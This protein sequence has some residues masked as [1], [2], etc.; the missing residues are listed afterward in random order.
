[1]T[2]TSPTPTPIE[3]L[4]TIH[5]MASFVLNGNDGGVSYEDAVNYGCNGQDFDPFAKNSKPVD[6]TDRAF[7]NWKNCIQCVLGMGTENIPTYSYSADQ[8]SCGEFVCFQQE[9]RITQ[10]Y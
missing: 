7:L 6:H 8:D 2:S 9:I 5:E 10:F 4:T 1:M 3:V